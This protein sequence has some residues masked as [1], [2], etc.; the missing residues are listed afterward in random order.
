MYGGRTSLFIGLVSALITTLLAVL[1][2]LLAGYYRGWVDTAISRLLEV[3][4]AFPVLLLAIALGITLAIG[5]LQIVFITISGGSIWIPILI[6][7]FVY[8]ALHGAPDPR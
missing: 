2:G 5:G 6:I 3:I 8:I 4:W 7:G 1:L